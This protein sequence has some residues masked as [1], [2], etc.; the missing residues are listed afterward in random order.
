MRISDW[1]SDVCSSDLR[2]TAKL[3]AFLRRFGWIFILA[4]GLG[5]CDGVADFQ[6]ATHQRQ[7]FDAQHMLFLHRAQQLASVDFK[8]MADK[9]RQ[10]VAK[11]QSVSVRVDLGGRRIINKKTYSQY[12]Q[13]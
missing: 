7:R 9:D 11:G 4:S 12:T 10:S 3:R 2:P 5:N 1:S 8:H 13:P 6:Q